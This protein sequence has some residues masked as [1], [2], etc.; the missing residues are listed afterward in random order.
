M[1]L[2]SH[3][4]VTGQHPKETGCTDAFLDRVR[5]EAVIMNI[6]SFPTYAYVR[7]DILTRLQQRRIKIYRTDECGGIVIKLHHG[8][9]TIEPTLKPSNHAEIHWQ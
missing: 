2:R 7:Q 1:D 4:I 3:I 5:P 6:G 9:Y 8:S